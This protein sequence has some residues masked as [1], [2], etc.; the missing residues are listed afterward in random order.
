MIRKFI[1]ALFTFFALHLVAQPLFVAQNEIL[2]VGEVIFQQPKTFSLPFTNKGNENLLITAV[3]PSCGCIEVEYPSSPIAPGARAEMKVTFDAKMLGSF[4]KDIEIETNASDKPTYM[5]IQGYVTTELTDLSAD[6]PIDLG[7]VRMDVNVL[8]FDD[9]NKGDQPQAT[10]HVANMERTAFRPQLMH[11]PTY[12]RA[13]Y[14]PEVIAAGK[15]GTIRLI[16]DSNAL[17]V[18]GLNQTK[19][20]LA[21]YMG[22]KVDATNEIDVSAVLLPDFSQLTSAQKRATPEFFVTEHQVKTTPFRKGKA[23]GSVLLLNM[24]KSPLQIQQLQVF[25]KALS[26]SVGNRTLAPGKSTK[27]KVTV[28][29]DMLRNEKN[30]A[31]I[32]LI[33]N[34]PNHPKEILEVVVPK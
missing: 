11:L 7:N 20:Y 8:E 13:E 12:L 14:E 2:K 1:L 23:T 22:D 31:R 10:L 28:S 15:T 5:A 33:S 24:G 3:Y 17:P 18:M 30:R 6:F 9:I 34:D 25:S 29:Q 26:V 4:Y 32:L 19:I 27:L 21:R 16:L